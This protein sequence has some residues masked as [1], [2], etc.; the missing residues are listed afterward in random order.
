MLDQL[1]D[2]GRI[3]HIGLAAGHVLEVL[4]VQQPALEVV[5]QQVETGF[6]HTPVDS[7]PTT[8]TWWLAS[9]SPSSTNPAVVVRNVRI[10]LRRPPWP[11]GT[12]THALTEALCTSSPAQRSMNLSTSLLLV[13]RLQAMP[14]GGASSCSV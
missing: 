3:R 10:S 7:I 13:L 11:S 6:Q 9:Q 5:F 2:P 8:W 1:G 12:P 14:P 4:G